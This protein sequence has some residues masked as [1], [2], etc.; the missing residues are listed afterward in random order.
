MS[1][2]HSGTAD[3]TPTPTPRATA[4]A[5]SNERTPSVA[6]AGESDGAGGFALGDGRANGGTSAGTSCEKTTPRDRVRPIEPVVDDSTSAATG[7]APTELGTTDDW[8]RRRRFSDDCNGAP[9][10][11]GSLTDVVLVVSASV[12]ALACSDP[13][14]GASCG[15]WPADW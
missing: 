10:T 3:S 2:W 7:G 8:W 4:A 5:A 9:V 1:G 6:T 12:L 11:N 15:G 13:G 14:N